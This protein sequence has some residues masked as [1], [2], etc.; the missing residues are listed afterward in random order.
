MR[1]SVAICERIGYLPQQPRFI[2]YMIARENL[3]FAAKFFFNTR[4]SK[5]GKNALDPGE[6]LLISNRDLDILA[7][8]AAGVNTCLFGQAKPPTQQIFKSSITA[9]S[10][11]YLKLS[12]MLE[13]LESR[14]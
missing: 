8:Q 2:E 4:K 9:N 1:E 11:K 13:T 14:N 10:C 3:L 6:T 5:P 12:I 7:G